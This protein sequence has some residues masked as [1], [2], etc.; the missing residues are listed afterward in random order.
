MTISELRA[1]L[2]DIEREHGD[3]PV[4]L[5]DFDTGW[6]WVSQPKHF[7]NDGDRLSIGGGYSDE[8]VD[9]AEVDRLDALR[10]E[11]EHAQW[12]A[13]RATEIAAVDAVARPAGEDG[14]P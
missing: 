2:A 9:Q 7:R 13:N 12:L 5:V 6:E 4:V 14:K 11:R 10:V 8:R 1:H 3:L